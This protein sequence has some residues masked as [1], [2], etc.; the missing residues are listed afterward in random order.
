MLVIR[1]QDEHRRLDIGNHTVVYLKTVTVMQQ[2]YLACIRINYDKFSP[3][4][5]VLRHTHTQIIFMCDVF[6]H[7]KLLISYINPLK[8]TKLCS[9]LYGYVN[10]LLVSLHDMGLTRVTF[11]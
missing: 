9:S 2:A 1:V 11:E 4:I 6:V 5:S 8:M 7:V 3:R 10:I